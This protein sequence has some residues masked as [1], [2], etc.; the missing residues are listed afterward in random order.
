MPHGSR[1]SLDRFVCAA[2][3]VGKYSASPSGS[4]V[5]YAFDTL[6]SVKQGDTTKWMIVYDSG[7]K[8]IHYRT[9]SCGQTKTIDLSDCDFDSRT[10]VQ[11]ISINT[12]HTGLLN[13][14][15]YHYDTDVNRWL[16]YYSMKHTPILKLL[17]DAHLEALIEYA[18]APSMQYLADWEVAGPYVR[19]EKRCRELFDI[20]FD[21]ERKNSQV[22]WRPLPTSPLGWHPA[23]LDLIRALKDVEQAV[24]YLRTQIV[25]D[26]QTPARL[27]LYSD[28]GVKAWLNGKLVHAHNVS[29]SIPPRPDTVEVMLKEGTNSLM[30]KVTQDA[31][32]WGAIVR[33]VER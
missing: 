16:V 26:R 32:P 20:V 10:P 13:P 31:G 4:I 22:Q 11:V 28:D 23:Y 33:L 19:Q 6:K 5:G 18:E 1:A 29:R 24:G 12:A 17:P 8:E 9:V 2:D 15:L 27:E 3:R 25:S 21:P 30:L 14:H 7:N